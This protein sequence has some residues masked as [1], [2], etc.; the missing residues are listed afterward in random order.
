M[1]DNKSNQL[2]SILKKKRYLIVKIFLY[3]LPLFLGVY[4]FLIE[5]KWLKIEHLVLSEN[6][7]LKI[8]HF[9]DIHYKGDKKYLVRVVRCIN[10]L[11]PDIVCFTGDLVEDQNFLADALDLLSKIEFPLYGV[12][13]NHEYWHNLDMNT[14]AVP[15]A[16]TGGHFFPSEPGIEINIKNKRIYLLHYP[17]TADE[18][19]PNYDIILAGHSHGGQIRIPFVGALILPYKAKKYDR[20]LYHTKNGPLYVNPGIGTF[21]IPARF[22]CRPEITLIEI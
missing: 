22:S 5:V 12:P 20:G 13:G 11:K 9:T 3:S 8:V 19:S 6:P 14:I 10:N 17:D 2:F 15:F 16:K 18:L 4:S 7:S 21:L 1:N